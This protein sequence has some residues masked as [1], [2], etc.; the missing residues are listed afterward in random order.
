M[1]LLLM[2]VVKEVTGVVVLVWYTIL[3]VQKG[4]RKGCWSERRVLR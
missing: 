3:K 1:L 2:F 4:V